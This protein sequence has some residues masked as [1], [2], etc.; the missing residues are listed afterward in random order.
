MQSMGYS[1]SNGSEYLNEQLAGLIESG[2][3]I[4]KNSNQDSK[5]IL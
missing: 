4:V 5:A 2:W 1:Y 3:K